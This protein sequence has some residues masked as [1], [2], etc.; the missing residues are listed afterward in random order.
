MPGTTAHWSNLW[1]SNNSQSKRGG[2]MDYKEF[3][4]DWED[5]HINGVFYSCTNRFNM[6]ELYQAFKNRIIDELK[7]EDE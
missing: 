6:E 1:I 2:V 4:K 5:Y 3:F 7:Q